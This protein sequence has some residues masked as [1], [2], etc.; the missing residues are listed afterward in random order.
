MRARARPDYRSLIIVVLVFSL[1]LIIY[2]ALPRVHIQANLKTY[3]VQPLL[4]GLIAWAILAF[5]RYRPF[6]KSSTKDAL[7][8]LALVVGFSQVVLYVIGG[9][10]SSFGKSPNGSDH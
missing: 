7:I 9:L 8:R 10:F 4:W 5:P 3:L 1:Y 6:A 2:A